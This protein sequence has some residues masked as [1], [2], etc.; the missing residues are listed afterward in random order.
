MLTKQAK[1]LK[2]GSRTPTF[3]IAQKRASN[4]DTNYKYDKSQFSQS[5][6]LINLTKIEYDWVQALETAQ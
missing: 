4:I 1:C 3:Y 6:S 2:I 5:L